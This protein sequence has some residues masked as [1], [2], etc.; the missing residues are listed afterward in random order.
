MKQFLIMTFCA[1]LCAL[2]FACAAE[3]HSPTDAESDTGS[4]VVNATGSALEVRIYEGASLYESFSFWT[5]G[6]MSAA[7]ED[8][9]TYTVKAKRDSDSSW[10]SES[11]T[12]PATITVS[13]SGGGLVVAV[14]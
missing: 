8:S 5:S 13:V 11:F 10:T 1:G 7:L 2:L 6:T 4:K 12:A 3:A 14:N 9:H